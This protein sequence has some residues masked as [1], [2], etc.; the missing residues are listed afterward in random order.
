MEELWE[1]IDINRKSTG[2]AHERSRYMEIP[3]GL[4]HLVVEIWVKNG[5][6]EMLLTQRHPLKHYG[7]MW[8][9]S[10]G[11]ALFGETSEQAAKRELLEETGLDA[12]KGRLVYLGETIMEKYIVDTWLCVFSEEEPELRLQSE[13]V[14][15]AVWISVD[16]IKSKSNLLLPGIWQRYERF[17]NTIRE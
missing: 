5:K 10:E 4:Y 17:E 6:E 1:L 13:E 16:E 9:C 3:D 15:D 11:S 14:V 7:L 2:I 8:E 12:D